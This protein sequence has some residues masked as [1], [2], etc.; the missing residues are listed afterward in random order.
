MPQ[1]EV[2]RKTSRSGHN[3]SHSKRRTKRTFR[4]NV[5]KT[6]V[7][8]NGRYV[9]LKVCTRCLRNMYRTRV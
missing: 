5:Q 6:R 4:A 8:Q 9:E 3:V 7:L 2:C 1:C